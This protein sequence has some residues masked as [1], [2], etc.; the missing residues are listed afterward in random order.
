MAV[1]K[2]EIESYFMQVVVQYNCGDIRDILTKKPEKAGP[3]LACTVNGIDI[4]GGMMLG[5]NEGSKK[6]SVVFM[7][8]HLGMTEE[9]AK[10]MYAL[11]RCGLAHEGVT[12]L[13]IQFFVHEDRIHP[14]EFLYKDHEN[15][16]WLNVTELAHCYLEA[17]ERIGADI[18]AHCAHVPKAISKDELIYQNALALVKR[19]ITEFCGVIAENQRK[20]QSSLSPFLAACLKHFTAGKK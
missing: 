7:R 8:Q 19:D 1:D 4:V 10:L 6:R 5:F 18:H 12:K 16:I 15:S 17:V 11:V 9:E 13:A 3:L 2:A 14:A 20:P